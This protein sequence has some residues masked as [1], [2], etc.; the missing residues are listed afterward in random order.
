MFK[1]ITDREKEKTEGVIFPSITFEMPEDSSLNDMLQAFEWYLKASGYTFNGS[2]EIVEDE[3]VL[4]D[5]I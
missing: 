2:I 5:Q 3:E 4:N 1:L